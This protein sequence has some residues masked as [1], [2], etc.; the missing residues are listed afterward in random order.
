MTRNGVG[1][2]AGWLCAMA[3]HAA[4][5]A[6]MPDTGGW[7]ARALM[8]AGLSNRIQTA[9]S[10][11]AAAPAGGPGGSPALRWHVDVDHLTGEPKY[12]VGWPR[13]VRELKD[14]GDRDWSGWDYLRLRIRAETTRSALPAGPVS[15]SLRA[16]DRPHSYS[17][18]L[19]EVKKGEWADILIPLHK[20]PHHSDV[21]SMTLSIAEASYS[22]GDRLDFLVA[23]V[24]LV[25]PKTPVLLEFAPE[26]SVIWTDARRLPI[27]FRLLG[28][29]AGGSGR[30][31]FE[32]RDGETVLGTDSFTGGR[33][34]HRAV[35]KLPVLKP[36]VCTVHALSDAGASIATATLTVVESPWP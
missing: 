11:I 18:A 36:G 29:P 24:S 7:E 3:G 34:A 6:P 12:P 10:T 15:L 21:R 5:P 9:E 14:P 19:D 16:P 26:G 32:V 4:G 27:R 17:R 31:R 20:I 23:D 33:G 8:S 30:V 28:V 13:I 2:L 25:R 22:H 35:V 1:I